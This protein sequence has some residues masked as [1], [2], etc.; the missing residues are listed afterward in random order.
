MDT[1][2]INDALAE[3]AITHH[4]LIRLD[5]AEAAGIRRKHLYTRVDQGLL[6]RVDDG[7][8][9]LTG[10]PRTWHQRLLEGCWSQG[11]ATLVSHR[12]AAALRRIDGFDRVPF[13][14]LVPRWQ[15]RQRRPGLITHESTSLRPIDAT[16]VDGIPCT[17]IVR[18]ILDLPAVVAPRRAEQALEDALRRRLCTIDQVASR[19]VQVARRG[20]RGTRVGR[21]IIEKRMGA[22]V[23]TK[24]EFERLVSDLVERAGLPQP[25]RQIKQDVR[26]TPVYID[27]GWKERLIGVECDG[28]FDHAT[29]L[30]LPWDDDRQ[31]DL[32]LQGWLILRF[33][34]QALTETPDVVIGQIR[35][36]FAQRPARPW[37][38]LL[39]TG[40]RRCSQRSPA[41][42]CSPR[43]RTCVP[44]S[45]VS[46]LGY[47]RTPSVS[48]SG[49]RRGNGRRGHGGR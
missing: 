6:T 27:L 47:A 34:W 14:V 28:L 32:Q 7:I 41:H 22:Y 19:F 36:A 4:A 46:A 20:R 3:L 8:F 30:A 40:V 17:S 29:N 38:D 23:P 2:S 18:T 44:P 9:R 1:R 13:E 21:L 39:R 11:P 24:T 42:A 33:T 45:P 15:R 43:L 25:Q 5:L 16:V 12:S 10:A 31:N 37:P 35:E 48:G 49:A 26:G